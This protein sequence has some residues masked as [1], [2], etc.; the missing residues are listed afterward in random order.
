MTSRQSIA[1]GVSVLL[2]VGTLVIGLDIGLAS[3]S[4]A[5][6]EP[7]ESTS[8]L[9]PT[10]IARMQAGYVTTQ[11]FIGRVEAARASDLGFEI[12]GLVTGVFTDEGLPVKAGQ[13][14]AILDT[15]RLASKRGELVAGRDQARAQLE[16]MMNGPRREDIAEARAD[17][18]QW[19]ARL[20]LF[21]LTHDRVRRAIE[22][23]AVSTL[24]WDE[25]R[26]NMEAVAAQ[27][28]GAQQRLAELETG[29]RIEQVEAQAALVRQFDSQIATLDVDL[30]KSQ[31]FAPFAGHISKRFVD[32]GQVIAAGEPLLRLLEDAQLE[33]RV[34]VARE[35][36]ALLHEGDPAGVSVAGSQLEARVK[37]VLPERERQTRTVT[38]LLE[39]FNSPESVRTGDLAELRLEHT[40]EAE[41]F[42]LPITALTE[43]T[44]GLWSCYVLVASGVDDEG[45]TYRI[46]SQQ[47]ELIH[48]ESDR[49]FVRGTVADGDRVV[50]DGVHRLTP[51]QLVRIAS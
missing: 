5:A 42:W 29:T 44:R 30:G 8:L 18:E 46:Q 22:L 2:G 45:G 51:G 33:A 13:A 38:V 7:V 9:V 12:A 39:L 17:V 4:Q 49:V 41:G 14:L 20:Q 35:A 1:V 25:A 3:R 23:N 40:V 26:L 10:S 6:D 48:T 28:R 37:A 16:E 15:A 34:G 50:S 21:R 27:L 31:L 43:S 47:L 11:S 19:Q 36:A 32:E 24:E